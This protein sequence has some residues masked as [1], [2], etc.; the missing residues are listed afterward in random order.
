MVTTV[1]DIPTDAESAVWSRHRGPVTGVV[2]IPGTRCAATSAYDSAIGLFDLDTGRAE[3][4]GYHEHLVN[5]VVVNADGTKLASCSS[6]YSIH[7]WDVASRI[8]ECILLGHSDDVEDFVFADDETGVSASRDRRIIV[9]NLR[10]G[11][12]R[13]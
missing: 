4:L 9:W 12:V 10:T 5:R 8:R 3:L 6:D 7:V 2:L 11:A 1:E 13:R